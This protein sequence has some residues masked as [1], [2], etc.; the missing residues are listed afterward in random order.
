MKLWLGLG[1][2]VLLVGGGLF[3]VPGL[4]N[5]S[6]PE[7]TQPASGLA[8]RI[9]RTGTDLMLTWNRDCETVRTATHAT[10]QVNDGEQH[11][12]VE[13][14]LSQ[15]RTGSIVYS[16]ATSDVS[17]RLE[18]VSSNPAK[19]LTE[20]VRVLKTKPSA[21]PPENNSAATAP[22]LPVAVTPEP[23][24]VA[25]EPEAEQPAVAPKVQPKPFNAAQ[26]ESPA[27]RL[28]ASRTEDLP[29]PP[30]AGGAPQLPARIPGASSMS[31]PAV[32]MPA[33]LAPA[34]PQPAA[35][36]PSAPAKTA[37][38]PPAKVGG[39]VV[40]VE[41]ISRVEPQYPPLARQANVSGEVLLEAVV[42]PNGRVTDVRMLSGH[43]LLREAAGAAVRKWTYRPAMLN[44]QPVESRTQ[45]RIN[46]LKNR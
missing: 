46:F 39:Q 3:F 37:P 28:R 40:P 7:A 38:P 41:L 33:P 26:L 45:I 31:M 20:S 15:L 35:Q 18:V 8:L 4:F 27:A 34:V 10:L 11:E 14:D 44:G 13:M 9:E 23:G 17:F 24:A 42:G 22:K 29:E 5:S 36:A 43:P 32:S 12:N 25:A 21:I 6:R 30:P 19:N 1:A 2:A 16:P